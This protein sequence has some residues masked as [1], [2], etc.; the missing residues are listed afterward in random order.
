MVDNFAQY[1][2]GYSSRQSGL[3]LFFIS[4]NPLPTADV[5]E[6]GFDWVCFGFVLLIRPP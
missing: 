5:W 4:A 2:L 6:I 3:T 1:R